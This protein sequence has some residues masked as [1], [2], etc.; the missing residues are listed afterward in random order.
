MQENY[1]VAGGVLDPQGPI[2]SGNAQIL[3][4]SVG[5]MLVIVI[6]TIFATL[7]FAWWFRAS[8]KNATYRPNWAHSGHLELI[9]W[10]I[11][12]LVVLFLSGLIWIGSH[13]LDPAQPIVSREKSVEIQVV[14]LDWKWLFIYP[15]QNIATINELTI[16]K[17]TPIH[18]FL[19]SGTVMNAFFVPQLASMIATM[20]GMV[21]HL[22]LQADRVGDFYGQSAQYSGKGFADMHF[23]LRAV[24]KDAFSQW[25]SQIRESTDKLD[26]D[27]YLRLARTRDTSP[28][29]SFGSIQQGIF[30]E[31]SM[32]RLNVEANINLTA[33][34][35]SH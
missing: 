26:N 31:I 35:T 20:N 1:S 11:P 29:R 13:E 8:N 6:P 9:V 21:T 30:E 33:Q 19:T 17:D 27:A 2:A 16:P 32:R 14:S 34:P 12:L 18:F 23:T 24:E 15:E 5:I 25:V 3:I 22:Y 4:N 7:L 10:G 28:I